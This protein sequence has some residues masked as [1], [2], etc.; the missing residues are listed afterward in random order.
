MIEYGDG[1]INKIRTFATTYKITLNESSEYSNTVEKGK[2][3]SISH[4]KGDII[5]SGDSI[6]VVVSLGKSLEVPDFTGM[7]LSNAKKVCSE[8]GFDCTVTYV[9]SY[10]DKNIV[11]GQNKR[12]GSE[13]IAGTNIVLY[14]SN[15]QAPS[16]NSGGSS[17]NNT[18]SWGGGNS[19]GGSKPTNPVT[20]PTP[21][22]NTTTMYILP[23]DIDT[24]A[25]ENTCVNIKN[26]YPGYSISCAYQP[27][28]SGIKG[29]VLNSQELKGITI[30]SCQNVTIVIKNN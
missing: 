25:P 24:Q 20:P 22:C 23:S 12:A 6:D 8:K 15:G 17:N 4:K 1:D 13:V 27:S 3:I 9:K 11:T 19:G 26:R 10:E 2:I 7:S 29:Q 5:N 14:V 21:T 18:P 16:S 30:N 28:N